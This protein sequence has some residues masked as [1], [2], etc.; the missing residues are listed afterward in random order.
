ME[1]LYAYGNMATN[2]TITNLLLAGLAMT[3]LKKNSPEA[4][5]CCG[6]DVHA[7]ISETRYDS[8][9]LDMRLSWFPQHSGLQAC[10]FKTQ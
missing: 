2:C 5:C 8:D 1:I 4:V 10:S 6:S 9:L 7:Y 3:K